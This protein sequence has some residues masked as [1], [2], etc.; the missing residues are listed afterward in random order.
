M[1]DSIQEI[2]N[3]NTSLISNICRALVLFRESKHGAALSLVA[4]EAG[5]IEQVTKAALSQS[6]YF[7]NISAHW[8]T[9]MLDDIVQA[10]RNGDCILL[11]DLL[12]IQMLRFL[13][14]IQEVIIDRESSHL[15][16]SADA[17][18]AQQLLKQVLIKSGDNISETSD[19]WDPQI[20][21]DAENLI[22]DGYRVEFATC[23][24]MTLAANDIKGRAFYI[25]TNTLITTEAF[26]TARA[27]YCPNAKIYH[28]YGFGL[29]YVVK[30]LLTLVGKE[31]RVYIYE[32]DVNILFLSAMFGSARDVFPDERTNI[33]SEGANE[34]FMEAVE[35]AGDSDAIC[36]YL[37]EL[38]LVQDTV[39][40]NGIRVAANA[41]GR[42]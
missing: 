39:T 13:C 22:A 18:G 16:D 19:I 37:P 8:L 29:G 38:R 31:T 41:A 15:F 6:E 30:E 4:D 7:T 35:R 23:G 33:V 34:R 3:I 10:Q 26:M 36:I 40:A 28:I 11:A 17:E 20:T 25:H 14:S 21:F 5:H 27:W 24:L 12:E 9:S 1:N 42:A 32:P 2:F